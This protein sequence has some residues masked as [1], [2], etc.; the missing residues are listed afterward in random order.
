MNMSAAKQSIT[1][2]GGCAWYSANELMK[3]TK[4]SGLNLSHFFEKRLLW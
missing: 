4:V 3:L 1:D 2:L